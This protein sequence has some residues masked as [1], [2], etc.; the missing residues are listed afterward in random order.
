MHCGPMIVP[1]ESITLLSL[2][3]TVYNLKK[4]FVRECVLASDGLFLK[5]HVLKIYEMFLDDALRYVFNYQH[6]LMS[7]LHIDFS[8]DESP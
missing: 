7:H 6:P 2:S 5:M 1:N 8:K 3:R 4:I